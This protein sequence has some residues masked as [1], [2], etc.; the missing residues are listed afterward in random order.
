MQG[1]HNIFSNDVE[2]RPAGKAGVKVSGQR[3]P[4]TH[5][6]T[7]WGSAA[8]VLPGLHAFQRFSC[9]CPT[10][11]CAIEQQGGRPV[12]GQACQTS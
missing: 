3:V 2:S 6:S 7:I 10:C 5:V 9:S 8:H 11:T 1:G 12:H 4:K